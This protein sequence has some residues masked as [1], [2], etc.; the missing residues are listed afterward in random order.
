MYQ[1]T[2]PPQ[3]RPFVHMNKGVGHVFGDTSP[4]TLGFLGC[5]ASYRRCLRFIWTFRGIGFFSCCAA[6]A[7]GE[8]LVEQ[9]STPLFQRTTSISITFF[10]FSKVIKYTSEKNT[11]E[12]LEIS[13]IFL[14]FAKRF[15]NQTFEVW[16]GGS[17][18]VPA[19]VCPGP[20]S[21]GW[22]RCE[23]SA[24]GCVPWWR[25]KRC[26]L[27]WWWH[28]LINLSLPGVGKFYLYI[29][30]YIY[31]DCLCKKSYE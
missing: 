18:M 28:F 19:P 26:R 23:I 24:E 29:S 10:W 8:F 31:I 25:I 2:F 15:P 11:C 1:S 16:N 9:V 12:T 7:T 14:D 17:Q 22:P 6:D 20:P 4:A 5:L 30:I 13:H 21:V 3:V 27:K